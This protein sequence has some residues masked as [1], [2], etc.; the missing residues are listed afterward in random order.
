MAIP[1]SLRPRVPPLP[2]RTPL[3][4]VAW[5]CCADFDGAL[6]LELVAVVEPVVMGSWCN[7]D[8]FAS[9]ALLCGL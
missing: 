9:R 2:K 1:Q 7:A 3:K 5:K 8:V 4:I 6:N